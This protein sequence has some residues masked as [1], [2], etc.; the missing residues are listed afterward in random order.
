M[1]LPLLFLF[2]SFASCSVRVYLYHKKNDPLVDSQDVDAGGLGLLQD[3]VG[4]FVRGEDGLAVEERSSRLLGW[5]GGL[6]LN[7][8][9]G[10]GVRGCRLVGC[11]DRGHVHIFSSARLLDCFFLLRGYAI[12]RSG[13]VDLLIYSPNEHRLLVLSLLPRRHIWYEPSL[14]NRGNSFLLHW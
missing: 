14:H 4:C 5:P 10:W 8:R 6:S 2:M 3:Q 9:L 11:L 7:L 13:M 1:S 12:S